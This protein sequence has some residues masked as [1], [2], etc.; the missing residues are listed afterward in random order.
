MKLSAWIE[1]LKER[2]NDHG[3][4]CDLCG[5]ELFSYPQPRLCEACEKS[6]LS[7]GNHR[8]DVCGRATVT[9]GVCLICKRALPAFDKGCSPLVYHGDTA[10]AINRLKKDNAYLALTFAEKMAERVRQEGWDLAEAVVTFVP[11]SKEKR[12]I[13]GYDQA[14]ELAKAVAKFLALPM[15]DVFVCTGKKDAQKELSPL[16]RRK[17][18]EGI[19]R[20]VERKAVKGKSVLLV[21]DIMTTGATGSECASRLKRAGA[22]KV[23]FVTAASLP[24]R[25]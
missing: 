12:R 19:Y 7:N 6:L 21:D 24:E 5:A 17:N 23:Y 9:E 3:Y 11:L 22:D 15:R 13:R 14:E 10:G 16:E 1:R 4:T 25:K 2:W 20:V 8:C 18:V